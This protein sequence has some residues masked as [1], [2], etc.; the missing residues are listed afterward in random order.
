MLGLHRFLPEIF[1]A[2]LM[3]SLQSLHQLSQV[4]VQCSS[5][6]RGWDRFC[7]RL[8][9]NILKSG[10]SSHHGSNMN[11]V[12]L[13]WSGE[14]VSTIGQWS[15]I[16]VPPAGRWQSTCRISHSLVANTWSI[17]VWVRVW[18]P[19]DQVNFLPC[20][21]ISLTSM[22]LKE[23]GRWS[24]GGWMVA[25]QN[26]SLLARSGQH[27]YW[28]TTC[29]QN[30][31]RDRNKNI[32]QCWQEHVRDWWQKIKSKISLFTYSHF[33]KQLTDAFKKTQKKLHIKPQIF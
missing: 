16:E 27:S 7:P 10:D 22:L 32:N 9:D 21:W 25:N 6:V 26:S 30:R 28:W 4:D 17:L 23:R 12:Y 8:L 5:F 18:F 15:D 14:H 19:L 31:V 3:P 29:P 20:R 2:L 13:A 1:H 24:E 33:N 11:P